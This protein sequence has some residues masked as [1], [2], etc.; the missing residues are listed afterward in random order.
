MED[1]IMKFFVKQLIEKNIKTNDTWEKMVKKGRKLANINS[2][3]IVEIPMS[4]QGLKACKILSGEGIKV[5]ITSISYSAQA[6]LA[7]RAGANYISP[8]IENIK[9]VDTV[10]EISEMFKREKIKT[11]ILFEKN[12]MPLDTGNYA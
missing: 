8:V 3:K 7:A 5:N 1:K 6:L 11:K 2:D 10:K 9:G 12:E 4:I